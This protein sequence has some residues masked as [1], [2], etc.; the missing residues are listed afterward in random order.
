MWH[1]YSGVILNEVK[2]LGTQEALAPLRR[3]SSLT[4]GMTL[5]GGMES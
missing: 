2:D 4:L 1:L 3:D 5:S